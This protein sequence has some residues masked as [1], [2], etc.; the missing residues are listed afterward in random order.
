[1]IITFFGHSNCLFNDDIKKQLKNIL[2]D[3]IIKN[4]TCK[5]YLGGYGD[6]DGLCLRTLRELKHDFPTIEILFI[7]PYLDKNYSKLEFAKYYYD[8]V[9]FPPIESVPRKFAILKR[10][11]WM[12]EQADLVIAYV[13]YSWG[14]AAKALEYAKRK[15]KRIINIA[16]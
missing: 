13:K 5:F 11:E 10:N 3:E 2:L 6:F 15:K 16:K 8:D 4:P 1:M 12:V 14:G 7:T 9:I